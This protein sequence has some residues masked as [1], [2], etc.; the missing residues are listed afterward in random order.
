MKP[1]GKALIV[2]AACVAVLMADA[3]EPA[4]NAG[5]AAVEKAERSR[6]EAMVQHDYAALDRLLSGDLTYGLSDGTVKSKEAFLAALKAGTLSYTSISPVE[7]AVRLYG[8]T[9]VVNGV[10]DMV[11]APKAGEMPIRVRFTDVYVFREGRWVMVAWQSARAPLHE[12][13]APP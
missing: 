13:Q 12:G 7:L 10:A 2:L 4:R 3:G 6:F 5:T 8:G 11:V 1:E 9:A